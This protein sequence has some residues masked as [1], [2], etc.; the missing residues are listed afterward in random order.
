MESNASKYLLMESSWLHVKDPDDEPM[1]VEDENGEPDRTKPRRLHLCGPGSKQFARAQA[2]QSNRNLG[3]IQRK[4]KMEL[5]AEETTR[6]SAEFL[7]EVTL[8]SENMED[9]CSRPGL[10]P[11]DMLRD[12]YGNLGLTYIPKQAESFARN[13][14]NFK[15]PSTKS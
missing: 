6:D 9:L 10:A 7:V 2:A 5:T 8:G 14:A 4:G 12:I 11:E 1:Y 15:R 13:T 3:R